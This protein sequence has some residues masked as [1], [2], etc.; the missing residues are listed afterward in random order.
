M[1]QQSLPWSV[2][3][4]CALAA[5]AGCARVEGDALEPAVDSEVAASDTG[6]ADQAVDTAPS[7]TM[8]GDACVVVRDDPKHC[9]ECDHD[10][11][12]RWC[13]QGICSPRTIADHT[14]TGNAI[15][16][17]DTYVYWSSLL[18]EPV[19]AVLRAPKAGGPV[20]V[21]ASDGLVD[22]RGLAL[23]DGHVYWV[24]N[25]YRGTVQ[26]VA[27]SGGATET[28][29]AESLRPLWV[30]TTPGGFVWSAQNTDGMADL[31]GRMRAGVATSLSSDIDTAWEVT[32]DLTHAYFF[33]H[34]GDVRRVALTGGPATTL[35][36]KQESPMAVALDDEHV[37]WSTWGPHKSGSYKPYGKVFRAPKAGGAPMEIAGGQTA[38]TSLAVDD[39]HVFWTNIG[40]GE[41]LRAKK[42]GGAPLVLARGQ[43]MPNAVAVDAREVY[44][45]NWNTGG[46]GV[47]AV[48]K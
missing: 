45:V 36:T 14:M 40:S 32:V 39:T 29:L 46:A 4:A 13:N 48:P 16:L 25:W 19:P 17:D 7:C 37:Y 38:P 23:D 22:M 10:C 5:A 9:G 26:R 27:K 21:L 8:C 47:A 42:T 20:E 41:V 15:A 31:V 18:R 12:G 30:A 35:A 2:V 1:V 34:G 24:N 43:S 44:W 33:T 28:V 3:I 11:A 6:V